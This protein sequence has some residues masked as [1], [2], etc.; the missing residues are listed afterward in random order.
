VCAF[1]RELGALSPDLDEGLS[2]RTLRWLDQ[3]RRAGAGDERCAVAALRV[4]DAV[5]LSER[6]DTPSAVAAARVAG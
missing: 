1:I 5:L 4:L 2:D 3:H 6:R